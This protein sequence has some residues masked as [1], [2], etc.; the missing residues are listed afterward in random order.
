ML[1]LPNRVKVSKSIIAALMSL[2]LFLAWGQCREAAAADPEVQELQSLLSELG[3]DA[4]PADGELGPRTRD[5]IAAFE[6]DQ[7]R[8][9][10]GQFYGTL[11]FHASVALREQELAQSPAG[12]QREAERQRLLSLSN[13]EIVREAEAIARHQG[14]DALNNFMS[15][16]DKKILE[17]LP[18]PVLFP[19]LVPSIN[20][21]Q[22]EKMT[23]LQLQPLS[24]FPS[25]EGVKQYQLDIKEDPTGIMTIGQFEKLQIRASRLSE[26]IVYPGT[27]GD[28]SIFR[29]D[30]HASVTGTWTLEDEQIAFPINVSTI[31][32]RKSEGY[33]TVSQAELDIPAFD[34]GDD[35]Y[36]L[37][38]T[39]QDYDIINWTNSEIIAQRE[40]E[41]RVSTISL[42]SNTN[43][44]FEFTRNNNSTN[45][46]SFS[47]P[48]LDKP[49]IARLAPGFDLAA[50]WW[51]ERK[52]RAT[53]FVNP[54]V[55]TVFL[56]DE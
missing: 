16:L 44:V 53:E 42:N 39:T 56:Q 10:T 49:R 20:A 40:R 36:S 29:F 48:Q 7:G 22:A 31:T 24:Y 34:G 5:A 46:G 47:L 11:L 35:A 32:C 33:C 54:R 26:T 25:I 37:H 19:L 3:Y 45:C 55:K 2:A 27:F 1:H 8:E 30:D 28:I 21:E 15:L 52:K 13:E 6:R 12:R 14:T 18:V 50:N 43:E 23:H 41:C 17:S 51:K 4:G 9:V 38:L